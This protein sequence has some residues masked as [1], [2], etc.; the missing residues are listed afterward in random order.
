MMT[1]KEILKTKIAM[2]ANPARTQRLA[3]F[4]AF[5]P[6]RFTAETT[7]AMTAGISP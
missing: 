4:R 1:T 3:D 2:N 6:M 7:M 5:E